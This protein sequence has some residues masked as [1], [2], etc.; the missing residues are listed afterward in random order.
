MPKISNNGRFLIRLSLVTSSTIA[1]V[2][3]AQS[4]AALDIAHSENTVANDAITEPAVVVPQQDITTTNVQQTEPVL[5]IR[6]VEPNIVVLRRASNNAT[7]PNI[8]ANVPVTTNNSA[9]AGITPPNAVTVSAP[10]PVVIEQVVSAPS[11]S[12][13]VTRSS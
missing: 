5:T 4:L 13:P 11:P 12:Q 9:S 7:T 6:N 2:V 10:P 8:T 3:G 1:A